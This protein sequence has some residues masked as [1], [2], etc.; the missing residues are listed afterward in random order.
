[1]LDEALVAPEFLLVEC[2][3]VLA[4]KARQGRIS[5]LGASQGLAELSTRLPLRLYPDRAYAEY[6][7]A[8][9]IELSHSAYDCLYLAVAL[10]EGLVLITADDRFRD[11]IRAHGSYAQ[12][13][14]GL[15]A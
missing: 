6:A 9:A 12:A 7:Q 15:E 2:A 13:V 10:Q 3:N 4:I 1:M 14:R 11:K 5:T 8:L